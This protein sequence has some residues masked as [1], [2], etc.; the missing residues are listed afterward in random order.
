MKKEEEKYLILYYEES[1]KQF[2]I[3]AIYAYCFSDAEDKFK[4]VARH[5]S[6]S[7]KQITVFA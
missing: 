4:L 1:E 5:W 3:E 7:I 2:K 6:Y